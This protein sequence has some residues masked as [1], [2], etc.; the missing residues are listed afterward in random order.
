[1][2]NKVLKLTISET[3]LKHRA[4]NTKLVLV[5]RFR[6]GISV[7]SIL[8]SSDSLHRTAARQD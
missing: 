3:N 6:Q 4:G 2:K 5:D 8:L 7:V 1:M